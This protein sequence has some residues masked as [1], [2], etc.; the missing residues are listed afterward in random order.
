MH[1]GD[2]PHL[3]A[4]VAT[5]TLKI[6]Q[7]QPQIDV[8]IVPVGGGAAPP[9]PASSRRNADATS[10][11]WPYSRSRSAAYLAWKAKGLREATMQTFAEG[12]ATRVGFELPQRILWT[13][14]TSFV[15]VSDEIRGAVLEMIKG[16]RNLAEPAGAAPHG[17]RGGIDSATN[18]QAS[19]SRSSV[20]AETSACHS[21][22]N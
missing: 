8:V 18:L 11:S 10:E 12:L 15:L 17:R 6:F 1:S 4:G 21:S 3:I 20:A 16:T 14:L 9:A 19:G 7:Q 13:L 5:I 22:N 2:E